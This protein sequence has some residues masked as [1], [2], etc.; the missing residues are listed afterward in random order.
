MRWLRV[1][2]GVLRFGRLKTGFVKAQVVSTR[3]HAPTTIK[4][5]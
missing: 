4:N 2:G 3:K 1:V 5:T